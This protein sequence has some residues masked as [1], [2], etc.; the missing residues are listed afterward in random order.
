MTAALGAG[1]ARSDI[2]GKGSEHVGPI[3]R[4]KGASGGG[5]A[6]RSSLRK[7]QGNGVV[8]GGCMARYGGR[9]YTQTIS[10]AVGSSCPLQTRMTAAN[11]IVSKT[12][13]HWNFAHCRTVKFCLE[14]YFTVIQR[15]SIC[16]AN[17]T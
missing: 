15:C 12:P 9:L 17:C 3:N 4:M 13:S 14:M 8:S 5:C 1:V 2:N 7:H 16:S 11:T 6:A 10:A